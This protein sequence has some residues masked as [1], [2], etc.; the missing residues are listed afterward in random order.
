MTY[1]FGGR[2]KVQAIIGFTNLI[3]I[4]FA[5]GDRRPVGSWDLAVRWLEM[6]Q[7]DACES[8]LV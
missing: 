6:H 5:A 2:Y 7:N 8:I 4:N 1:R 3:S